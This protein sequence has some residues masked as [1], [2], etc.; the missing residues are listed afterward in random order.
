MIEYIKKVAEDLGINLIITNTQESVETQLNRLVG[1]ES[2]PAMLIS[3][4]IETTIT[5]DEDGLPDNPVSNIVC[6]LVTK[7]EDRTKRE[8]QDDALDMANLF[9]KFIVEL[10][11][12]L[13]PRQ[14]NNV[15][16]PIQNATYT[17]AP[18][19][20]KGKHSGVLG[21]FSMETPITY[22]PCRR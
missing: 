1:I 5:F 9:I 12:E 21:R 7:P 2:L 20:G 14:R 22:Y 16:P 10:H 11:Q 8:H 3:W 19:Y 13:L 17:L 4:D 18:S 15:V 6:L